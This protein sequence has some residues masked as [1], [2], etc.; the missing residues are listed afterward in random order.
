MKIRLVVFEID[1]FKIL[2][3]CE[4]RGFP[5]KFKPPYHLNY[6]VDFDKIGIILKK[7]AHRCHFCNKILL[8]SM[9][10]GNDLV[11]NVTNY[12]LNMKIKIEVYFYNL[13]KFGKGNICGLVT[14]C[15]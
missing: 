13:K 3:I 7:I 9:F 5:L 1:T 4:K 2:I 6:W 8:L 14:I 15:I 11:G 12:F 10:K